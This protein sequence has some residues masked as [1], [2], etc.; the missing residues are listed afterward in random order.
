MIKKGDTLIEVAI[1]IGVFSVIAISVVSVMSSGT[2]SAQLAL[3]T[4]LAREEIDS[5][6]ESLRFIHDTYVSS[7]EGIWETITGNA[8]EASGDVMQY[9]PETC[10]E[11]YDDENPTYGYA[12][13]INPRKISDA[14]SAYVKLSDNTDKIVPATTYPRLI[15]DDSGKLTD[16]YSNTDLYRAEGIY[17]VAVKGEAADT[18]SY[19]DFYIRSCWYGTGNEEPSTISTVIRLH[20]PDYKFSD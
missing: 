6:A 13:V 4:T 17:V 7:G 3:E 12:F 16:D 14:N 20:N 15:F 2:S 8:V 11:L 18:P 19:Y 1:A 5:Q 10:V 9:S